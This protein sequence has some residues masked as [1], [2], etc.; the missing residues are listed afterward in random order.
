MI[1]I[2]SPGKKALLP[3]TGSTL[4]TEANPPQLRVFNGT[5][6][7]FT[8]KTFGHRRCGAKIGPIDKHAVGKRV[9]AKLVCNV[10]ADTARLYFGISERLAEPT[11]NNC[12]HSLNCAFTKLKSGRLRQGFTGGVISCSNR[13]ETGSRFAKRWTDVPRANS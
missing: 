9:G 5:R 4:S 6:F 11:Q 7:V 13:R 3:K 10:V 12:N 2:A 1:S 8:R